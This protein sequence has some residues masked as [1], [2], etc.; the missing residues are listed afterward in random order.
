M[1][2]EDLGSTA[3]RLPALEDGNDAGELW[4]E[5]WPLSW[6]T[7]LGAIGSAPDRFDA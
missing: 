5:R 3:D 6:R 7:A 4:I 2:A 1:K